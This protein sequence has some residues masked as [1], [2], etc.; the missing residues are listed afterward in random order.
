MVVVLPE[1]MKVSGTFP[2][3]AG[4]LRICVGDL[5]TSLRSACDLSHKSN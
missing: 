3:E 4:D 1:R 2:G 5:L